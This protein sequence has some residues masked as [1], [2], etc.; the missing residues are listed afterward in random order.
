MKISSNESTLAGQVGAV[1]TA[2]VA[3]ASQLNPTGSGQGPAASVELSSEAQALASAHAEAASYVPVVNAVPDRE[4]KISALK[5]SI[6][7]GTYQVSSRDIADQMV[8][9]S[10]A[11][12]LA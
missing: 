8:R 5:S 1:G 6:A 2:P 7:A 3:P 11:D 4:D 10:Q 12:Q 9:R